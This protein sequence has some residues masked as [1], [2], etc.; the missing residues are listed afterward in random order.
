MYTGEEDQAREC[1]T[2]LLENSQALEQA[3]AAAA[4]GDIRQANRLYR[5][6]AAEENDPA[7]KTHWAMLYLQ[8]H[9]VSDA[10]ALFR[11]ALLYDD[12][13][14]PARTGLAASLARGFEGRARELLE[15][16]L[17]EHPDNMQA[18]ML[19]ARIELELQNLAVARDLLTRAEIV[20]DAEGHPKLEIYALRAGANLLEDKPLTEWV[21]KALAISCASTMCLQR[22]IICK[23]PMILIRLMRKRSTRCDYWTTW[24]RCASARWMS[25]I[26]TTRTKSSAGYSSGSI[27][28]MPMHWNPT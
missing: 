25:L 28:K 15:T 16:I 22:D 27:V 5:D 3:D 10:E 21:D 26:R 12:T 19:L 1:Y 8:T 6:L 17:A 13:Y 7:I 23:R 4:L 14:L 24:T 18:L 20:A 11:E 9:Q 2:Q